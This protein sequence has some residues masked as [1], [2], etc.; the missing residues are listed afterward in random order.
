VRRVAHGDP[1][2]PALDDA[3][4]ESFRAW[5]CV[6][7]VAHF[8]L[9][10]G[11]GLPEAMRDGLRAEVERRAGKAALL[12]P[13]LAGTVDVLTDAGVP[14]L[15]LKGRPFAARYFGDPSVRR[16]VDVD[17]LVRIGDADPAL[18]ALAGR[19]YRPRRRRTWGKGATLRIR[20]KRLRTEHALGFDHGDVSVDLH[21]RLRTAPAYRIEERALWSDPLEIAVDGRTYRAPSDEYTLVALLLSIA[22]DIG[23]RGCRVKHV[24]DAYQ[25]LRRVHDGTD[26]PAFL[27]RRRAENTLGVAV[28]VLDLVRATFAAPGEF[29]AL[30]A[31]LDRHADLCVA[32]STRDAGLLVH[33]LGGAW[34]HARWFLDVYP[35]SWGRDALWMI[36]R[37]WVGP[38]S[39]VGGLYHCGAAGWW[40]VRNRLAQ[41]RWRRA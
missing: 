18:R 22:H 13:A 14:V 5:A 34:F 32:A 28:N 38:G 31:A 37:K 33:G 15:V 9:G 10:R 24:L 35:V 19:G 27:E 6:H 3:G 11:A 12:V 26:W 2:P 1:V 16:S 21:W 23:R 20:R 36:D 4:W 30:A 29:P 41:A 7:H 8:L 39:L 17:L 25:V 40:A